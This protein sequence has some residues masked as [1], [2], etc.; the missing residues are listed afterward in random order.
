MNSDEALDKIRSCYSSYN[1]QRV[2]VYELEKVVDKTIEVSNLINDKEFINMRNVETPNLYIPT[3]CGNY[4]D[5]NAY[6]LIKLLVEA[7]RVS[8]T[9]KNEKDFL[10]KCN[11]KVKKILSKHN[12][13]IWL[14]SDYFI[15]GHDAQIHGP[16][17]IVFLDFMNGLYRKN[18]PLYEFMCCFL[19]FC[20]RIGM[21]LPD[22]HWLIQEHY[23]FFEN[24]KLVRKVYWT[25]KKWRFHRI[26]VYRSVGEFWQYKDQLHEWF[27]PSIVNEVLDM[28]IWAERVSQSHFFT[29][30]F[31]QLNEV[32]A[33]FFVWDNSKLS[34]DILDMSNSNPDMDIV[35]YGR[36]FTDN[37]V[38]INTG[39][40][41][42]SIEKFLTLFKQTSMF[43]EL[44]NEY[45]VRVET[46][47]STSIL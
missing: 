9:H 38:V 8:S 6:D 29:L 23:N 16:G 1:Y 41:K 14:S 5:S 31:E 11:K 3:L 18:K 13:Q 47:K 10:R 40:W 44:E 35:Q 21:L 32:S 4:N 30:G 33:N 26:N 36:C 34:E 15:V 39:F 19:S 7:K 42:Q 37:G 45:T 2:N 46:N 27:K 43:D 22:E 28:A 12:E 17:R 24:N 20:S 25:K